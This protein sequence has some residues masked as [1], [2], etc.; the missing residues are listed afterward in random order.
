MIEDLIYFGKFEFKV[1]EKEYCDFPAFVL[2]D[3]DPDHIHLQLNALES[4]SRLICFYLVSL[5]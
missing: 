2:P 5:I 1:C 3:C 4:D